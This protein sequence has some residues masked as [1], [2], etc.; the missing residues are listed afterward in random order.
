MVTAG[1]G[2][3]LVPV[4]VVEGGRKEGGGVDAGSYLYKMVIISKLE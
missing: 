4:V 2:G 1:V 3:R